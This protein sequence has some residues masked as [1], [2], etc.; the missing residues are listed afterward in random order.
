MEAYAEPIERL[1]AAMNGFIVSPSV[2]MLHV[3]TTSELRKAALKAVMACEMRH[4]N[5][6]PFV[7]FEHEHDEVN[8]GWTERSEHARTQHQRRTTLI[9][10]AGAPA[11]PELPERPDSAEP[12]ASFAT[13]LGQL[14]H[15]R[16][17]GSEGLVVV[18]APTSLTAQE[19]W[20]SS[21]EPLL[22]DANMAEIRLIVL[23]TDPAPTRALAEKLGPAATCVDATQDAAQERE[24]TDR[25]LDTLCAGTPLKG[26][27]PAMAPPP[28][29]GSPTEQAIT[30]ESKLRGL[31][32]RK[33]FDG[34]KGMRD[35]DGA[36]AVRSFR[37]ARDLCE[38]SGLKRDAVT[39]EMIIG[40]TIMSVGTP[41]Q[42]EESFGRAVQSAKKNKRHEQEAMGQFAIGASKVIRKDRHAALVNYAEGTVA[43]EKSGQSALAIE[44]GRTTGQLASDLG[45]E[46]QAI[47]F[48]T[49]SVKLAEAAGPEAPLTSAGECARRLAQ[50]CRKR[51]LDTQA[52]NFEAKSETLEHLVVPETPTPIAE[53]PGE[54]VK[55][56]Q[57]AVE[58][59]VAAKADPATSQELP[60]SPAPPPATSPTPRP[61]PIEELPTPAF[62]PPP[63]QHAAVIF[64]PP[65]TDE[66]EGTGMLTLEDIAA[67]HWG[68]EQASASGHEELQVAPPTDDIEVDEPSMIFEPVQLDALRI[69]TNEVLDEEATGMLTAAE[70]AG[71]RGET[72]MVVAP[73]YQQAAPPPPP[74]SAGLG[75]DL[76]K[77]AELRDQEFD[78]EHEGGARVRRRDEFDE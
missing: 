42:A 33:V 56:E 57:P 29:P 16:P 5:L 51:G 71:L 70:L 47:A 4:N 39:L 11:Q 60:K 31:V 20:V 53:D 6:A 23:E 32:S 28:H 19:L 77:I 25:L 17:P 49:K 22:A 38:G 36:G 12:L 34:V 45:M 54:Q 78:D 52:A 64:G 43:A 21:L 7:S 46:A 1:F 9:E 73:E 14:L 41:R 15:A 58:E 24:N 8:P 26:A 40:T 10:S 3:T 18:L 27:T 35:G 37:E 48:W 44:G 62:A 74:S 67:I 61:T 72:P 66:A 63:A 13:Q 75:F 2:R 55:I 65:P 50:L 69:A 30:P 68:V 59:P 76:S